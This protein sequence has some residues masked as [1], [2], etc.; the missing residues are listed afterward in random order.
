MADIQLKS[1]LLFTFILFTYIGAVGAKFSF[2]LFS[3]SRQVCG[4]GSI[5]ILICF[6]LLTKVTIILPAGSFWLA[7]RFFFKFISL[8]YGV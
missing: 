1:P 8:V 7:L 3:S 2:C 6:T 5:I 4:A